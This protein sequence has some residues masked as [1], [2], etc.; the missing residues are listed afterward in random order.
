MVLGLPRGGMPV[1]SVGLARCGM[2]VSS[3]GFGYKWDA[4]E[5]WSIWLH[6]LLL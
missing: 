4:S 1:S 6:V 2:S 3:I 5:H